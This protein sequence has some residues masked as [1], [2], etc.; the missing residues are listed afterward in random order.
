LICQIQCLKLQ[1]IHANNNENLNGYTKIDIEIIAAKSKLAKPI[2]GD[3][4][5]PAPSVFF[6][7]TVL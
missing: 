3:I 5:N 2:H 7:V 4:L 1:K 6:A